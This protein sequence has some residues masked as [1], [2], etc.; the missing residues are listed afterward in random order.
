MEGFLR[1]FVDVNTEG[2]CYFD[3]SERKILT[4]D[5]QTH[6]HTGRDIEI[7]HTLGHQYVYYA[8]EFQGCGNGR[9]GLV[10]NKNE[11]LHLEDD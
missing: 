11:F 5:Y 7:S 4:Q 3:R 6:H 9:Y 1:L 8:S 10:A 2:K